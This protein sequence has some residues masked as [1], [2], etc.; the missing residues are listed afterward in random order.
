MLASL[1]R[2]LED[3]DRVTA[4]LMVNGMVNADPGYP[5]TTNVMYGLSELILDS[6]GS[7]AGEHA[8]TAIGVATVPRNLPLV[9]SA[10]V[11]VQT[12]V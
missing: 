6:Y 5:Q 2:S 1:K 9:I 10:E 7:Q 4:W 11:E 3:L 12:S 8:R